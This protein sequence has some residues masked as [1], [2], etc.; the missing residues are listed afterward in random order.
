MKNFC[1]RSF[2]KNAWLRLWQR[3]ISCPNNRLTFPFYETF[4]NSIPNDIFYEKFSHSIKTVFV[5][6][7][8]LFQG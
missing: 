6:G 8:F 4:T 3:T 1:K 5:K 7:D 2:F